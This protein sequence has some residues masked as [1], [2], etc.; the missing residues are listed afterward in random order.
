[1]MQEAAGRC[2]PLMIDPQ[3]Q[4]TAFVKSLAAPVTT[5]TRRAFRLQDME[6]A[7]KLG[8]SVL[9]EVGP[10]MLGAETNAALE[11]LLLR[12]F[13]TSG[14]GNERTVQIL[15][16]G[17]TAKSVDVNDAFSLYLY[18]PL[19][20][21]SFRAEIFSRHCVVNF[22]LVP[23]GLEQRLLETAPAHGDSNLGKTHMEGAC[24]P[25]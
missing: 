19:S 20:N 11:H 16:K 22:M 24:P 21:P 17:G 7:L 14:R 2:W 9:L 6:Y 15:S 18:C 4:G 25:Y 10:D 5:I 13:K 3:R 23:E 12:M 8:Q 1:M